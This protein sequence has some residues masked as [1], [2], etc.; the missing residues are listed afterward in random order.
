MWLYSTGVTKDSSERPSDSSVRNGWM[1]KHTCIQ[2]SGILCVIS[3]FWTHH[4]QDS[5]TRTPSPS[6]CGDPA[7]EHTNYL[8]SKNPFAT[9]SSVHRVL[10]FCVRIVWTSM[11][12]QNTLTSV[13]PR[14]GVTVMLLLQHPLI[15]VYACSFQESTTYMRLWVCKKRKLQ[16]MFFLS[17]SVC[18]QKNVWSF[19]TICNLLL[20]LDLSF[21]VLPQNLSL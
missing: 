2:N 13:S 4:S 14:I 19:P 6:E 15:I 7:W 5:D 18:L 20:L 3:T 12:N 21:V 9:S 17:T 10:R 8:W 16:W 1:S 11:R